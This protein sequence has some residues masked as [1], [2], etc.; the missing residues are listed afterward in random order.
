MAK[1]SL[2]N[3]KITNSVI[4][5][6]NQLHDYN[7]KLLVLRV[8]FGYT[9]EHSKGMELEDIKRDAKHMLDNRRSNHELFEHQV[10]YV[11]KFEHTPDKG[12]HIHALF[13]YNGQQVQKDAYLA[14]KL[15]HYWN[16]K[17]T[18][19]KGVYHNCNREK[20]RY[21]QCGI[22]MI[23]Y[24][25]A[26]KRAV[27]ENKVVPYMLKAEQS[28]DSIKS[29]KERSVTKGVVPSSK[30]NAGRPRSH[31]SVQTPISDI[32]TLSPQRIG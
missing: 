15:G 26:E 30:S 12:P 7:S 25:D 16:E 21:D 31:V 9:K 28:I 6:I 13:A 14:D 27:L 3:A 18:D 19:G 22:G 32:A 8:D 5:Y 1:T 11:M 10:G 2:A 17:I 20:E 29:G 23:D 24:S 4:G